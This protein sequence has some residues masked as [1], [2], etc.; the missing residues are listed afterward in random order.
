[1]TLLDYL[2]VLRRG[3]WVIL[4]ITAFGGLGAAVLTVTTPPTYVVVATVYVSVIGDTT[5]TDLQSG[6]AFSNQRAATY[7]DLAVTETVLDRA[8]SAL[9]DKPDV[10]ELRQSVTSSARLDESLIDITASGSDPEAVAARANA[11]AEALTATAPFLDAPG[12][13]PPV[14]LTVVQK[15]KTPDTALTP[16]PRNNLMIGTAVG[17]VL[18]VAIVVV[19]DALSTRIRSSADLP[20]AAGL[21]TLTSIPSGPERRF[22]HLISTDPRVESFRQLRANLQFGSHVEETIAV[23]G[24][25]AASD[26]RAVARQL[27]VAFAEIGASVVVV[28]LDLRP[29]NN[30]DRRGHWVD[31]VR[32]RPGVADVLH[33]TAAVDDVVTE[34]NGSGVHEVPAGYVDGSSAQRMSTPAMRRMLEKLT[35]RFDYVVLA[36][37]PLVERS[38]SAVAAALA[39]SAL[40][41]VESGATRRSD[42]LFALELLGGVRVMSISV[43]ID[44]VR[45]HD[46]GRG[47]VRAGDEP[48][49]LGSPDPL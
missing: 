4:L 29:H 19:A 6:S 12:P 5:P 32:P 7:A 8:A 22:R 23:A 30:R 28:D 16:R 11:V 15:A 26:A 10:A 42:F 47:H 13:D 33:G 34:A 35:A 41:V 20:R 21:V 40:V 49:G 38:E 1:V 46:L 14:R 18:G 3:W 25:T 37:P 2:R 44:H 24:V 45:G 17:L 9:A 48:G 39:G 27:A 36:S 43:V 31:P